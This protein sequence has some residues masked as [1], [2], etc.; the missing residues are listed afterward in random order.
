MTDRKQVTEIDNCKSS[1]KHI[2]T[3]VPQGSIL[4]PIL[5][6]LYIN[7][8]NN[9]N[10]LKLLSFADDTTVYYSGPF[11]KYLFDVVN[12][13]LIKIYEWLCTNR[14]LLNIKKTKVCIFGP[15]HNRY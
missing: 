1:L 8:I 12:R 4:G 6:L 11:N 3:G 15:P 9:S 5:F 13:E 14:L 10:E 7:Y 2:T